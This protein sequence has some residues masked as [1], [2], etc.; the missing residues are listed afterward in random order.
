M[1]SQHHTLLEFLAARRNVRDAETSAKAFAGLFEHRW[2]P[3]G[4][5]EPWDAPE[6]EETSYLGFA[7]DAWSDTDK[8]AEVTSALQRIAAHG[9]FAGRHFL[10][11]Q[12][13]QGTALPHSVRSTLASTL[14]AS[15]GTPCQDP[16]EALTQSADAVLLAELG[17][18][19][20][21]GVRRGASDRV[22]SPV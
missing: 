19:R 22:A 1:V 7:L 2:W 14:V 13:V 20:G 10:V 11:K 6:T 21:G 16:L 17:D 15:V 18:E 4:A 3:T 12:A 5:D 8:A 9:G